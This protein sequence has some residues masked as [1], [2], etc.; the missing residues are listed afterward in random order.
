MTLDKLIEK[1]QEFRNKLP[2]DTCK[3]VEINVNISTYDKHIEIEARTIDFK[4]HRLNLTG[5]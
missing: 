2:D 1:L 3:K 4:D 5:M